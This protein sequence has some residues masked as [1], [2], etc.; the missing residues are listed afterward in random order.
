MKEYEKIE[1]TAIEANCTI[2]YV[3]LLYNATQCFWTRKLHETLLEP[4]YKYLVKSFLL[5]HYRMRFET[6]VITS[7]SRVFLGLFS[8]LYVSYENRR[9]RVIV[10]L[11]K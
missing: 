9:D 7:T 1:D 3:L 10:S 4:N 6:R 5:L 2:N 11:T 8:T